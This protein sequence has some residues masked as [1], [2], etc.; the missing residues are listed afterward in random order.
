M[1][2]I[3][4]SFFLVFSFCSQSWAMDKKVSVATLCVFKMDGVTHHLVTFKYIS[5]ANPYTYL[6][7]VTTPTTATANYGKA[8]GWFG[9]DGHGTENFGR[10]ISSYGSNRLEDLNIHMTSDCILDGKI[11]TCQARIEN[12][13]PYSNAILES[14]DNATCTDY[15]ELNEY[16]RP[17]YTVD[18]H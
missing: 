16:N 17:T 1:S 12:T 15:T 13:V 10:H 18:W 3:L 7:Y 6:A 5:P 9:V 8:T 2:K 11:R 14:F 4:F